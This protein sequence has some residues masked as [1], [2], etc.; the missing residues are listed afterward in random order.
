[1][2]AKTYTTDAIRNVVFLGHGG[3]GKTTLVDAICHAAGATN[4]KGSVPEGTA[5]TDFTAE[6]R[7]HGISIGLGV[8]HAEWQGTKL[9]L[10]DTPGF[11][12]F[13]GDAA[14]GV[15]IADGAVILV[16]AT[17]GVLVGTENVWEL[18]EKRRIPR[19]FVISMI[20][21]E[22]ANF[23]SV[24]GEIREEFSKDAAPLEIPI[25][26]GEDFRGVVD[27]LSGK[28]RIFDSKSTRGEYKEAE[29]P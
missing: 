13:S 3:T 8:A 15:R 12:D 22:N 21:K 28:A 18:C 20:D 10:L 11:L 14:A 7:D 4:R 17:A 9:N 26:S 25:G 27:L 5:L 1:M 16:D 23:D 6:E 19:I 2:A 24:L 29:I